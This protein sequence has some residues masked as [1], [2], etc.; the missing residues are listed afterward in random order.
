M[1][2]LRVIDL[3]AEAKRRGLRGY[4]KLRKAELINFLKRPEIIFIDSE[5]EEQK[6]AEKQR[7]R[8]R[9]RERVMQRKKAEKRKHEAEKRER[10]AEEK[11]RKVEKEKRKRE[12]KKRKRKRKREIQKEKLK[13]D[14]DI[15]QLVKEVEEE[16]SRVKRDQSPRASP[17]ADIEREIKRLKKKKRKVKGKRKRS[18]QKV[19]G[20]LRDSHHSFELVEW[21]SALNRFARQYKIE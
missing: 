21:K 10:E 20:R 9:L 14:V 4:S 18:L 6:K 3:K 19:I 16:L 1:E 15:D 11:K 7:V 17:G 13:A 8:E 12:T 2:R 5:R